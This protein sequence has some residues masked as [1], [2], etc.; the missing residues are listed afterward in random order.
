[1]NLHAVRWETGV[2]LHRATFKKANTSIASFFRFPNDFPVGVQGC[3]SRYNPAETET[4]TTEQYGRTV[5]KMNMGLFL[6]R[7][8]FVVL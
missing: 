1:M 7:Q 3:L 6:R 5:D 2:K 4:R 8:A